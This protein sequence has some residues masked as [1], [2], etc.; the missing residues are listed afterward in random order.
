MTVEQILNS[1]YKNISIQYSIALQPNWLQEYKLY[2]D[3]HTLF[4]S[5]YQIT[6]LKYKYSSHYETN[7]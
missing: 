7:E 3:I 6:K 5:L 1:Y 2:L 4:V